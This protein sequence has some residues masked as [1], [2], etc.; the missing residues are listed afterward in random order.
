MFFFVHY[1]TSLAGVKLPNA[2]SLP[3]GKANGASSLPVG[4]TVGAR[5]PLDLNTSEYF[6]TCLK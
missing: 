3:T 4:K 6:I 2:L 1:I 5:A